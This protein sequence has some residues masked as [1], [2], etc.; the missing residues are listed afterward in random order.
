MEINIFSQEKNNY[1]FDNKNKMN[2]NK[3]NCFYDKYFK[4]NLCEILKF[5]FI[6]ILIFICAIFSYIYNILECKFNNIYYYTFISKIISGILIVWFSY[7]S[8]I[9]KYSKNTIFIIIFCVLLVYDY[10]SLIFIILFCRCENNPGKY[11]A[12]IIFYATFCSIS[13]AAVYKL[14]KNL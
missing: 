8:T 6:A 3:G 5:V 13:I 4:D 12:G 10:A 7:F 2:T 1:D 9:E 14:F 11:Y